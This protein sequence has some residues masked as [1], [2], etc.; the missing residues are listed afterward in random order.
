VL[1][2]ALHLDLLPSLFTLLWMRPFIQALEKLKWDL[3]LRLGKLDVNL[4]NLLLVG[5]NIDL[6]L[7]LLV[8]QLK[9]LNT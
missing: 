9:D 8:L 6:L 5:I 4:L 3:S 1:R 2:Q 7:K